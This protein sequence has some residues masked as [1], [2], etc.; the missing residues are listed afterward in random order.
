VIAQI[1]LKRADGG[2]RIAAYEVLVGTPAVANLIRE[3]QIAQIASMIQTG[4]RFGMQLMCDAVHGLAAAG[5]IDPAEAE[6]ALLALGDG[7]EATDLTPPGVAPAA[8]G[9]PLRAAGARPGYGF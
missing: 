6:R 4:S 2:G 9:Q 1:L 7:P 5:R 3:N 8:A